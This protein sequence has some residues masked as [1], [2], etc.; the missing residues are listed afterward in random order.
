MLRQ[1]LILAFTL[2]SALLVCP[3]ADG[4]STS[5]VELKS[6]NCEIDEANF[7]TVRVAAL[8][9]ANAG[10]SV[11]VIARRGGD[12]LRNLNRQRLTATKEWLAKAHFPMGQL[13]TAE[14]SRTRGNGRLEIYVGGK[15]THIIL[16]RPSAGLCT[17][18]CNPRP[19]DFYRDRTRRGR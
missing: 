17:E 13:V 8:P 7:N 9:I 6:Q 14:G 16:A 1:T 2:V 3:L 15:L 11:I 19:E 4:Q 18:C 5:V 12:D 10:G